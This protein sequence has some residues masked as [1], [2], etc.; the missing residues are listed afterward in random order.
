MKTYILLFAMLFVSHSYAQKEKTIFKL[1][2]SQNMLMTGKGPGQDGAINPYTDRNSIA[3]VENVGK[4][5]FSIRLQYEGKV[6]RTVAL[7]AGKTTKVGLPK[8]SQL[9]FDTEAE[10]TVKLE[11]IDGLN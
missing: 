3:I 2:P 1:K 7:A 5:E 6:V 8:G 10:T 11:F 4:N 9:Y